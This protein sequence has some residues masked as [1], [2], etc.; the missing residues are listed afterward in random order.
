MIMEEEIDLDA[1]KTYSTPD[2]LI[3]GNCR[4]ATRDVTSYHLHSYIFRMIFE[5]LHSLV[6]HKRLYCKLRFTCK[7]EEKEKESIGM[8]KSVPS[9][10]QCS[11]CNQDFEDPWDL[12]EHVQVWSYFCFINASIILPHIQYFAGRAHT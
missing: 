4:F 5:S 3:C 7:C 6:S 10:L 1:L 9:I 11:S 8:E 12:M 2:I